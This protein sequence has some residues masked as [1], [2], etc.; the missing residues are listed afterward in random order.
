MHV[1]SKML[2][3]VKIIC[4]IISYYGNGVFWYIKVVF[5]RKID[6]YRELNTCV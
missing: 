2:T 5:V 4:K 3:F 1:G 6:V